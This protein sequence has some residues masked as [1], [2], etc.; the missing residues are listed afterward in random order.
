MTIEPMMSGMGTVAAMLAAEGVERSVGK[1]TAGGTTAEMPSTAN[2]FGLFVVTMPGSAASENDQPPPTARS[3][4][5][6]AS[7]I[8]MSFEIS[9]TDFGKNIF[10]ATY[11][12]VFGQFCHQ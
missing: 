3:G 10:W 9:S 7:A 6:S 2:A 12:C 8:R 5:W 1:L 11:A 4:R